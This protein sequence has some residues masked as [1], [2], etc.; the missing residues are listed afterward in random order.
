[1]EI[2]NE[3]VEHLRLIRRM[4]EQTRRRGTEDNWIPFVIWGAGGL[5][6]S[7]AS[8]LL[9]ARGRWDLIYIPWNLYW[10]LGLLFSF[11]LERGHRHGFQAGGF[12]ARAILMTW[13]AVGITMLLVCG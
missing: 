6:A 3:A 11:W 8:Q 1:M 2:Q 7:L 10:P 12:I 13:T 5:I 4:M 9:A